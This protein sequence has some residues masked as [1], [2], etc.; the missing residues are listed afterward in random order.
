MDIEG[1][2]CRKAEADKFS[3]FYRVGLINA[4]RILYSEIIEA[5]IFFPLID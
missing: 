5:L 4:G 1:K 3:A 2:N